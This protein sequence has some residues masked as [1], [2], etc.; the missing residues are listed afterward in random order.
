MQIVRTAL[1]FPH[2][3]A[4]PPAYSQ[5]TICRKGRTQVHN[6]VVYRSV[7]RVHEVGFVLEQVVNALDDVPFSQHDLVPDRHKFIL[8]FSLEPM[9]ELDTLIEQALEEFLLDISSVGKDLPIQNLCKH[10]PYPAIPTFA[11]VRQN[12]I[13]SPESL[14]SRCSL[15]P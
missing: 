2:I 3:Q 10:R 11:P 15:N 4:M 9:N 8:H 6:K 5:K 7:S 14:Q 1:I 12:V 13:T